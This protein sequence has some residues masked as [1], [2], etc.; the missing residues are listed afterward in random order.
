MDRIYAID[1]ATKLMFQQYADKQGW[2]KRLRSSYGDSRDFK[3][4]DTEYEDIKATIQLK[5]WKFDY[6]PYMDTFKRLEKSD[7]ILINDDDEEEH[8]YYIMTHTDGSY[9]DTSGKW[10]NWFDERIPESN[11]I[12]SEPLDD[13]IYNEDI[14]EVEVGSRRNIGV[15]PE[16]Y[17]EI[18]EDCVT[19]NWIHR[20]DSVYSEWYDSYFLAEDAISAITWIDG[21]ADLQD[22]RTS[23]DTLSDQDNNLV[24]ISDLECGEY[25]SKFDHDT[26]YVAGDTLSKSILTGKYYFDEHS[27]KVYKTEKGNFISED[28]QSLGLKT[29]EKNFYWTDKFS[30]NFKLDSV[31][32]QNILKALKEKINQLEN[33][34]SGKQTRLVFNDPGNEFL[35]DDQYINASKNLLYRLKR[36]LDNLEGWI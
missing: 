2:L 36:R 1:D 15:Y 25:M 9:N 6:Y 8:G 30:Y 5:K 11:A 10:S 29:N 22:C 33:L 4:G 20:D 28:C 7:G 31:T 17:D 16:D 19:K 18:V 24:D 35:D 3:L 34:V 14:V 12:Y 26:D 13:W 21:D 32:K 27:I 23:V